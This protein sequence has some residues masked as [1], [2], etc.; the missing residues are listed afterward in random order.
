M[1]SETPL[2]TVVASV[3]ARL[4]Q[5][6]ARKKMTLTDRW[7]ELAGAKIAEH[8]K[9]RFAPNKKVH[10]WVDNSTLAFELNMKHGASL[11]KRLKNEFRADEVEDVRFMV[12]E[13]RSSL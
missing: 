3:L 10:V 5:P 8:T 13:I 2:K 11:L 9:A 7:P 1:S 4:E 6:E 12:G